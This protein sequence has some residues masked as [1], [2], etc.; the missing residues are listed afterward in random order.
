VVQVRTVVT[1]VT[2]DSAEAEWVIRVRRVW[3]GT[4]FDDPMPQPADFPDDM[5]K[6]L[7]EWSYGAVDRRVDIG[8]P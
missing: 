4:Y 3:D 6:A 5:R 8:E 7:A 2:F 1:H